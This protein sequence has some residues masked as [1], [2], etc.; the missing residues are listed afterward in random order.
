MNF[1]E[2]FNNLGDTSKDIKINC[3][4]LIFESNIADLSMHTQQALVLAISYSLQ[5]LEIIEAALDYTTELDETHKKA[6]GICANIMSMNNVYYRSLHLLGNKEL[7]QLPAGL[8]MQGLMQHQI[9]KGLF[10][11]MALAISAIN[12]CGLCLT[13]HYAQLTKKYSNEQIAYAIKLAAVLEALKQSL[14]TER[15]Q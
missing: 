11:L 2:L 9:D 1:A 7:E 15:F 8:R 10:E 12:G 13:S 3:K 4:K 5:N 14:I 6:A